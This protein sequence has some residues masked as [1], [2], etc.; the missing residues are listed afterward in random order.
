MDTARDVTITKSDRVVAYEAA[1][2][3]GAKK[4]EIQVGPNGED[5]AHAE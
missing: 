4:A 5:L 2:V 1:T 3:K